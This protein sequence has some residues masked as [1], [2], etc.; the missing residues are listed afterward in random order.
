MI[1]KW[2]L[3]RYIR[4]AKTT[5][6]RIVPMRKVYRKI[7]VMGE[8]VHTV[9]IIDNIRTTSAEQPQKFN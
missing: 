5:G 6:S 7:A 3:T 2:D 9:R 4:T 1:R 8:A